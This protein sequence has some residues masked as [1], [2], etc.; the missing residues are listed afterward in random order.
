[1][2]PFSM[3]CQDFFFCFSP[4]CVSPI[5]QCKIMLHECRVWCVLIII[6]H[7]KNKSDTGVIGCTDFWIFQLWQI[8]IAEVFIFSLDLVT[9]ELNCKKKGGAP[10]LC[11]YQG[12]R[13]VSVRV[14]DPSSCIC[15]LRNVTLFWSHLSVSGP[16]GSWWSPQLLISILF[17]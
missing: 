1:M 14:W 11:I 13:K 15:Q 4:F 8:C 6:H 16:V 17:G 12:P 9:V 2:L 10:N 3:Q 7:R 5:L